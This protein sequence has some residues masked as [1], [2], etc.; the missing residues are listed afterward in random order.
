MG[1]RT[2]QRILECAICQRIPE[3]GEPM[4]EMNSDH[5]CEQCCDNIENETMLQVDEALGEGK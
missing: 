3:D 1:H 5:W 4:W 2:T